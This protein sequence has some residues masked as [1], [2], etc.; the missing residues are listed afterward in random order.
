MVNVEPMVNV[1][2][3]QVAALVDNVDPQMVVQNIALRIKEGKK[4]QEFSADDWMEVFGISEKELV[5]DKVQDKLELAFAND[6]NNEQI[7]A[8]LTAAMKDVRVLYEKFR[9]G[10]M[11]E[12]DFL[13]ESEWACLD[14]V[15]EILASYL[16]DQS[17]DLKSFGIVISEETF[18]LRY[19]AIKNDI[20][21]EWEEMLVRHAEEQ[22]AHDE[23]L[24][25]QYIAYIEW[26]EKDLDTYMK[27]LQRAFSDDPAEALA[28]S[29][30]L[31]AFMKLPQA[32]VLSTVEDVDDFFLN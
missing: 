2:K 1:V 18:K 5:W 32:E 28:G 21:G 4:I 25:K 26:L 11:S 27:L 8:S 16:R 7:A 29:A 24:E 22:R 9:S 17:I 19:E 3:N 30:E 13:Y 20:R 23:M 15:V 31:A 12:V 14:A 6:K 10:E